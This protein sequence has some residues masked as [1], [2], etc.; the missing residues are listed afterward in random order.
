[1]LSISAAPVCDESVEDESVEVASLLRRAVVVPF[2]TGGRITADVVGAVVSMGGSKG[3]EGSSDGGSGDSDG[4]TG[5][6]GVSGAEGREGGSGG[7][8]GDG[9]SG[10]NGGSEFAG[11]IGSVSVSSASSEGSGRCETVVST[12]SGRTLP[13]GEPGFGVDGG[14]TLVG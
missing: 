11:G 13:L 3:T 12:G 2:K 4:V 14:R 9:G 6:D 10:G 1:M 7:S 5:G 8:G